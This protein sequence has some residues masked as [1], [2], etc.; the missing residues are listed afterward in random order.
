MSTASRVIGDAKLR[1]ACASIFATVVAL[2][3]ADRMDVTATAIRALVDT[4]SLDGY[5]PATGEERTDA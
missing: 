5:R 4:G 1:E 3:P 2:P